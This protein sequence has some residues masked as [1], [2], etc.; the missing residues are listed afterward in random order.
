QR[1][2]DQR[3]SAH[4]ALVDPRQ[5]SAGAAVFRRVGVFP[6][7]RVPAV[8]VYLRAEFPYDDHTLR[9][10]DRVLF[11]VRLCRV[12]GAGLALCDGGAAN[13]GRIVG[14]RVAKAARYLRDR[15]TWPG[16]TFASR[17]MPPASAVSS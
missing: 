7:V 14:G 4:S 15:L 8:P 12:R 9:R 5:L 11:R 6:D 17:S 1:L 2:S 13:R 16:S 3:E 10:V